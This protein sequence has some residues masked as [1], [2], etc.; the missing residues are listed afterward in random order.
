MTP[1]P[2]ISGAGGCNGG[3]KAGN[4]W[5]ARALMYAQHATEWTR[6]PPRGTRFGFRKRI[7]LCRLGAPGKNGRYSNVPPERRCRR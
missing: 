6:P 7:S 2:G 4:W 1:R 5:P 3:T